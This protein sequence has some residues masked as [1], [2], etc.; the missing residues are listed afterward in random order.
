TEVKECLEKRQENIV[1]DLIQNY[2][3]AIQDR[4]F[5]RVVIGSTCIFAAEFSLNSY[6]G[7]R[8]SETFNPISIG[9]F[10]IV[11]V[12]MLSILNIQNMLLVV[13]LTFIINRFIDHISG[14]KA[15]LLGLVLYGIGYVAVTSSNTWYV[16]IIFNF[17]ATVGE[18][19][20]SPIRNAEQANMIPADK[21]GSYSAFAGLSDIGADLIARMTIIV[22]AFLIPTMMSVYIGMI[23]IIGAFFLYKGLFARTSSHSQGR[24]DKISI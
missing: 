3:I 10:E 12:R 11:G 7:V 2:K 9:N 5:L 24:L 8:L 1:L 13:C 4:A 14:K 20:Y 23:V 18:L 6:I 17:I 21:R 19:V 22:G 16:L 15:L